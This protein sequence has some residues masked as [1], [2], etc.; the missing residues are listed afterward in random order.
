MQQV[1]VTGFSTVIM[2]TLAIKVA[3]LSETWGLVPA[4]MFLGRSRC[5]AEAEM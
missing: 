2:G 5:L 3:L 4:L 1:P